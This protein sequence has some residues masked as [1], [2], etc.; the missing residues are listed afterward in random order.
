M[1]AGRNLT[2]YARI[3]GIFV[4]V[5]L[6]LYGDLIPQSPDQD[7]RSNIAEPSLEQIRAFDSIIPVGVNRTELLVKLPSMR[8]L[9]ATRRPSGLRT[10]RN[11][12]V[13]E[14]NATNPRQYELYEALCNTPCLEVPPLE[15][16]PRSQYVTALSSVPLCS[17]SVLAN[18][19]PGRWIK[20]T[21]V[22]P[23]SVQVPCLPD[24]SGLRKRFGL[25]K[26][27]SLKKA[28][29]G[30]ELKAALPKLKQCTRSDYGISNFV[31]KP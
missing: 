29:K 22:K 6:S 14:V 16:A 1:L 9:F 2:Q 28:L 20:L 23:K 10:Y 17:A 27:V 15:T 5:Y 19:L 8:T 7:D 30:P 24:L 12:K 31:Y 3:V 13:F 18:G 4:V 11:E 26:H 21:P 25:A